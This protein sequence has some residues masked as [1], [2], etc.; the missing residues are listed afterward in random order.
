MESHVFEYKQFDLEAS[1]LI[2]NWRDV[3][4]DFS[5]LSQRI[6]VLLWVFLLQYIQGGPKNWT[7]F[8]KFVTPVYVD[9]EYHSVYQTVQY[10][11]GSKSDVLYVTVFKYSLR[12]F[13][14]LVYCAL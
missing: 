14:V 11:I 1:D 9:I 5:N 8:W 7:V 10:F 4:C 12:N 13:S 6:I 3:I 2:F